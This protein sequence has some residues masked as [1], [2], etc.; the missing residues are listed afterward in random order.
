M[1]YTQALVLGIVQGVTEF[2]PVSSSGHLIL[3]PRLFGWPDQGLAFD[4]AMHLGTLVALLA[5]FHVELIELLTGALARRLAVLLLAASLPALAVGWL[6]HR[7]VET[8]LR[9]PVIIA[10]ATGVW[11]LV[12]WWA[13]RRA[14]RSREGPDDPLVRVGWGQGLFVG[15]AQVLALIPGT[16]RS[17]VTISAGLFAHLDRATAARFSFLL[18]IPVTGAAGAYKLLQLLRQGL[19]PGEAGPLAL[20][21]LVAFVSGW[22][23]VWFLVN[24]LKRRSLMP[25]V[26]YRLILAAIIFVVIARS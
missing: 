17:G 1:T 20:A 6:V 3:V 8:N 23:A 12:M 25:F 19:P 4:A 22:A 14:I 11:G 21:I 5:Y 2:L 7:W 15:C 24:Y 10:L 13:D 16:S 18:G 9:S 26:I